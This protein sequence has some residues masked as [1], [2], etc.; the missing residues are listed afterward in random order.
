MQYWKNSFICN[1]GR[2]VPLANEY[3]TCI[4]M[5]YKFLKCAVSGMLV[6]IFMLM[7]QGIQISTLRIRKLIIVSIWLHC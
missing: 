3:N 6:L 2:I 4:K 7:S 5:Q 1:I